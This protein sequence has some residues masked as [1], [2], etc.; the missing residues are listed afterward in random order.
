MCTLDQSLGDLAARDH[1]RGCKYSVGKY[2]DA[3]L[4]KLDSEYMCV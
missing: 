1:V 3:I 4:E 2:Y